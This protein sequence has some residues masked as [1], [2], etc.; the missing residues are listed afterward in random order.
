MTSHD[1]AVATLWPSCIVGSFPNVQTSTVQH[2]GILQTIL[3]P[4]RGLFASCKWGQ[5]FWTVFH[6]VYTRI[7]ADAC[8]LAAK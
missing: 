6:F 7:L 8:S 5:I 2:A 1:V 3:V 4:L